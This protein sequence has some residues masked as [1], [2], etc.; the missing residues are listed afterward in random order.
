MKDLNIDELKNLAKNE[1][2]GGDFYDFW[3]KE[4]EEV[5]LGRI[6][7]LREGQYGAVLDVER[8]DGTRSSIGFNTVGLVNPLV[9]NDYLE[10]GEPEAHNTS[11]WTEMAKDYLPDKIVLIVFKGEKQSKSGK[12]KFHDFDVAIGGER[13]E[14]TWASHAGTTEERNARFEKSKAIVATQEEK[15]VDPQRVEPGVAKALESP[16][17]Q[18]LILAIEGEGSSGMQLTDMLARWPAQKEATRVLVELL[19]MAKQIYRPEGLSTTYVHQSYKGAEKL[20][21][22]K[23]I[24]KEEAVDAIADDEK[25]TDEETI[26]KLPYASLKKLAFEKGY[27]KELSKKRADLERYLLALGEAGVAS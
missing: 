3:K 14:E 6:L 11:Y 7:N 10:L 23:K 15:V 20:R 9:E 2:I 21:I 27:S 19:E 24:T 4:E 18:L 25:P 26:T 13:L 8:P 5:I 16:M 12:Q 17:A 22:K 1:R